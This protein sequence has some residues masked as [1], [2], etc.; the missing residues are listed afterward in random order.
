MADAGRAI[1]VAC[2]GECMVELRESGPGRF[3][4]AFAGDTFNTAVYLRRLGGSRFEVE[5]ASGVGSDDFA[6]DMLAFWAS[7]GIGA[8]LSRRI[9][10][11]STGLYSIRTDDSGERRFSYWRDTSAARAYFHESPTPLETDIDGV[12]VLFISGISLAVLEGALPQRLP[13]LI[14]RLRARGGQVVF[15]SNYRPR[16]WPDDAAARSAFAALYAQCDLALVTLDDEAALHPD[17]HDEGLLAAT[18]ALPPAELVVK[19]GS[20]S[21]LVRH[22]DGVVEVPVAPVGRVVDTTAAGDSFAA[23]Y[24]CRRLVGRPAA[25]AADF[26][27]RV[28]GVVIGRPGAIVDR[29]AMRSLQDAA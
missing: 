21:T 20:A 8:R 18:L 22:A 19:R 24:L 15:D 9:A 2:L 26:G 14:S 3:V 25:D 4:Q 10:G 6:D 5:Y 17:L 13:D 1:R 7:E 16:L 12:D 29:E 28:A 11:R 27:N 23:G